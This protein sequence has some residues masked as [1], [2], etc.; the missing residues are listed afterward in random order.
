MK[1]QMQ[2]QE[3]WIKLVSLKPE[4]QRELFTWQN[5]LGVFEKII[6]PEGRMGKDL[7]RQ[8]AQNQIFLEDTDGKNDFMFE[9]VNTLEEWER[10]TI[11]SRK[12]HAKE[13]KRRLGIH[14]KYHY[15][16]HTYGTSFGR[17]EYTRHMFSA[18]RWAM[19]TSM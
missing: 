14:F 18:I 8:R 17:Q 13:I 9:M 4:M 19:E 16:R 15:L 10:Q 5:L 2:Y 1:R 7:C 6:F 12:C 3:D 11:N